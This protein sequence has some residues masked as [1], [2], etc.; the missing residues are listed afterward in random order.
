MA[1][2][3]YRL[4]DLYERQVTTRA[5]NRVQELPGNFADDTGQPRGAACHVS[6]RRLWNPPPPQARFVLIETD[7]NW[8][9]CTGVC[10]AITTR[11]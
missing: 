1:D 5:L 10:E 4:N 8:R 3:R 6:K 7:T 9:H 11:D 2:N